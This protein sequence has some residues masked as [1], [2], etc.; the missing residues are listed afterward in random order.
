MGA[1]T[2]P[3]KYPTAPA[4][5]PLWMD[6]EP[7]PV[8]GCDVCGALARERDAARRAGDGSKVSDCNVEIR[9]HPHGT[10]AARR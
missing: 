8:P 2:E 5:L 10:K 1:M 3:T 7:V 6:L 9:R 4:E